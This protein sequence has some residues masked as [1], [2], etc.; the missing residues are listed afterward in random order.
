[1]PTPSSG[2]GDTLNRSAA[3]GRTELRRTDALRRNNV[4]VTGNPTG[5]PLVFGHGYGGSQESWSEVI[6]AFEND[7]KIVLFDHVGAGGSDVSAYDRGKYDSLHG[8]ADDLIEIIEQ[9]ELTDVVYVGHSVS[10]MMGVL[11]SIRAPDRI[12]TLVLVGPSPR[13]VDSDS[14][15]Y[16]GAFT[17]EAIDG[18]LD[19]LDSNYLG[20]SSVMAPMIM[21]NADRPEL[22]EALTESFTT[23]DP[24]IAAQFARVTFLSDNRRDLADV[25]V[26]TLILQSSDDVIAPMSVGEYVHRSIPGSEMIV[27]TSRGHVPNLSDPEQVATYIRSYLR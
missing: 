17:Q 1:M 20:W 19:S 4:R 8:Y 13:Y 14:D 26:P 6:P 9:L 12:G 21:G 15:G 25:T 5:R 3:V 2:S 11:A 23:V 18:L 22:G 10:A 24:V 16:S 27:M 7:F